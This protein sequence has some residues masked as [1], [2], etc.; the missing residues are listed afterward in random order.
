RPHYSNPAWGTFV[1]YAEAYWAGSGWYVTDGVS[2]WTS[3]DDVATP[4]LITT[5]SGDEPFPVL[6]ME[7]G[8]EEVDVGAQSIVDCWD[9]EQRE[10][11][12]ALVCTPALPGTVK[13]TDGVD[14]VLTVAPGG[15]EALPQT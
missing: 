11:I 8:E 9:S 15:T 5:W 2:V 14:D 1:N 10:R 4:D 7:G 12:E 13:T 3:T 6:T